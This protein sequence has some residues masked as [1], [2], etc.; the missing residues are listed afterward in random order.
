MARGLWLLAGVNWHTNT[1]AFRTQRRRSEPFG[2][3]L[4]ASRRPLTEGLGCSLRREAVGIEAVRTVLPRRPVTP[5]TVAALNPD[6]SPAGLAR[7]IAEIGYPLTE[8]HRPAPCRP[9]AV[10]GPP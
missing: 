10:P 8:D 6:T 1:T 9:L 5:E 2:H 3:P 7:D 4:R